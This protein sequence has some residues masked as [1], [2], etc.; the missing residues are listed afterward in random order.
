MRNLTTEGFL[1]T[2]SYLIRPYRE[3]NTRAAR[4]LVPFALSV[5]TQLTSLAAAT[6]L[7]YA[8]TTIAAAAS[9]FSSYYS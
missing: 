1:A 3:A 4:L 9:R 5:Y 2:L 6:T 7:I 8:S